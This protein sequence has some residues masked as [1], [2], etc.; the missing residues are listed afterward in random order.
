MPPKAMSN[1]RPKRDSMSI[2]EA[3]VSNMW[4]IAAIVEVLERK[5]LCTKHDLYNI[6]TEF[7]RK[8][9]SASIPETAFP[10]PYLLTETE[11]TIIDGI[12]ELL[13]KHGLTSHQSQNLL[14]RLGRIIEM[15]QRLPKG[16][17]H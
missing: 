12:L 2:E 6:I 5:G 10:E 8:N 15:G 1:D 17:T 9:P 3:T 16:T 11:N 13:N 4:E 7:R 14:E